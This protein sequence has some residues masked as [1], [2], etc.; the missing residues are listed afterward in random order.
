MEM[1]AKLLVGCG[2]ILSA[3]II[4]YNSLAFP[5]LFSFESPPRS[6][7]ALSAEDVSQEESPA[8]KI[9]INTASAW[10]LRQIQG[11]GPVTAEKIITYREKNGLFTDLAQLLEIEGI[12][13]KTLEQ[14]QD[15][16]SINNA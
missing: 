12:G 1:Q 9:N 14:I 13:K 15:F 3:A 4:F 6:L 16:I 10:Q 7:L 2:F 8:G 11:I 5:P